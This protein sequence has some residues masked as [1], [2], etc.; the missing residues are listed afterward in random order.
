MA[1]QCLISICEGFA[2]FAFPIYQSIETPKLRGARISALP[3]SSAFNLTT[4]EDDHP[5]TAPLRTV[6]KMVESAWPGLL[7]ALSFYISTNLSDELFGDTLSA[8]Q[9][10]TNVAGILG[11]N[12]PR[13]AF[14]TSLARF[15]IPPGVVSS[16]DSF[17]EP[18]IPKTATV[19]DALGFSGL[20]TAQG[21]VPGLSERN[22]AC[23][24]SIIST[25]LYLRGSLGSTWFDILEVLQ[26]AD[27]VMTLKGTHPIGS[28]KRGAAFAP[29][30][31]RSGSIATIP[32]SATLSPVPF[33]PTPP[34]HPLL[35]DLELEDIQV[36][37]SK[38]FDATKGLEDI[39]FG[40]F[41]AA[42]CKLSGEMV[43]MQASRS[44]DSQLVE[45]NDEAPSPRVNFVPMSPVRSLASPL[46]SKSSRR[47]SGMA[48]TKPTVR[49]TFA[50]CFEL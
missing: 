2:A 26:N 14:L 44:T 12:T 37:V 30:S 13:D 34:P 5:S 38:L 18:S 1:L 19:S 16:V 28:G 23:L 31:A 6:G 41:I 33:Q 8:F 48:T 50:L 25:A 10:L 40:A 45:S 35:A 29:R 24:K 11:L 3:A 21:G 20:G 4:L 32:Q 15:A 27:Y 47:I 39:A 17:V 9:N 43:Q 36:V 22:L 42:L 49:L 7:S 46:P